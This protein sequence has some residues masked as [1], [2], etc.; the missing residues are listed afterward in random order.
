MSQEDLITFKKALIES[1]ERKHR[2]TIDYIESAFSVLLS[3]KSSEDK[4]VYELPPVNEK[5][6]R[7]I[8]WFHKQLK[9]EQ[10]KGHIRELQYQQYDNR[11]VIDFILAKKEDRETIEKW[12]EWTLKASKG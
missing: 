1:L 8:A 10:E 2:E 9:R 6:S 7:P 3:K 4:I 12:Y 5:N 11:T